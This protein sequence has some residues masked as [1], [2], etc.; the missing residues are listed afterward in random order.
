VGSSHLV[1]TM[2]VTASTVR[3]VMMYEMM[4]SVGLEDWRS[5]SND[6]EQSL[7]VQL[8]WWVCV[9]QRLLEQPFDQIVALCAC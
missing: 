5:I 6:L 1:A 9:E 8:H 7:V 4:E 2:R 3:S